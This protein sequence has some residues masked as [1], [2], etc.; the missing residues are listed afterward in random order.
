MSC[1]AC[2]VDEEAVMLTRQMNYPED[3]DDET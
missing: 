3:F 1:T 2:G